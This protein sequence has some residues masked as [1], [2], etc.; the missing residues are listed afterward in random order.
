MLAE[1]SISPATLLTSL[2]PSGSRAEY[3]YVPNI[4]HEKIK[5]FTKFSNEFI[6]LKLEGSRFVIGHLKLPERTDIL[7]SVTHFPSKTH[8]SESS[9][10]AECTTAFHKFA[11]TF[12]GC[13]TPL[14]PEVQCL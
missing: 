7:L 9:L 6:S 8:W 1:C 5:I 13:Q 10:T 2:N 12:S 3:D 4:N 11:H 14:K